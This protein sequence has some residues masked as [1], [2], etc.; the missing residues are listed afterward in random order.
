M[1]A[2]PQ[3]SPVDAE[4]GDLLSLLA[5]DG[6]Y[7]TE[8]E[9]EL[10]VACLKGV[11]VATNWTIRPNALRAAIAGR[12]KPQRVGA[13]TNRAK[14]EG[15]IVWDGEWEVSDDTEGRNGGKPARIYRWV[16]TP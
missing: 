15:L 4:T 7:S 11:A 8:Y 12:I 3:W 2:Q 13:F 10:Y 9:W 14:A 5:D 16:G 6:T 1:T